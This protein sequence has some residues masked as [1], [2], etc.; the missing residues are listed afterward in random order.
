MTDYR[1]GMI[2]NGEV[3]GI[4]KY[5]IFVK[6]DAR[7]DGLIHI[8]EISSKFV[9]NVNDYINVGEKIRAKVIEVDNECMQLKLSIK[10]LDYKTNKTKRKDDNGFEPLKEK[11]AEW[12]NI[13]NKEMQQ[14]N[15]P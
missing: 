5:G 13:K 2:I 6:I 14:T 12:V 11:L 15:E 10:D 7:Y 3:T 8:S 4:A 9:R 1:V